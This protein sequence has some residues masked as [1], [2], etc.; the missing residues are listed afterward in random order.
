MVQILPGLGEQLGPAIDEFSKGLEKYIAPHLE[1]QK[2]MTKAIGQNPEL[3]QQLSDLEHNAPGTLDR[4]GFGKLSDVIS[5]IPES[6]KSAFLRKNRGEI[7]QTQKGALDLQ[8]AQQGFDLGRLNDTINFL[9]DPKNAAVTADE[10]LHRL[11]GQTTAE[12]TISQNK[13]TVSS[14]ETP[15]AVGQASIAQQQLTTALS[16]YKN[17]AN[18]NFG[19][20]ARDMIAGRADGKTVAA[21]MS[22]DV[23]GAREAL[24]AAFEVEKENRQIALREYLSAKT[25]EREVMMLGKRDQLGQDKEE[26]IKAYDAMKASGMTG[27][28]DAWKTVLFDPDKALEAQNTEPGKRTQQQKD[29]VEALDAQ[30][31]M[32]KRKEV[33]EARMV[34][35]DLGKHLMDFNRI[36]RTGSEAEINGAIATINTDLEN[37]YQAVGGKRLK[38]VW[39][40]KPNVGEP[41]PEGH[42]IWHLDADK[43]LFYVDANTGLRVPDSDATATPDMRKTPD[44]AISSDVLEIVS[45]LQSV[46]AKERDTYLNTL[47]ETNPTLYNQV[48][49]HFKA[50][51]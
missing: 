43:Q 25:M 7:E 16:T 23:P 4:M 45:G 34:N 31:T 30:N 41:V 14:A 3:A 22:G 29:I 40:Y 36:R 47:K 27:T 20:I 1:F 21:L 5:Q 37:K 6:E 10:I 50:A 17:L 9:K 42:G 28:L 32:Q 15:V 49:P 18:I 8:N 2:A 46:G 44:E 13:A 33:Y 51:K 35:S 19:Q 48:A 12:R 39:W 24:N 38:A 11:T 26:T